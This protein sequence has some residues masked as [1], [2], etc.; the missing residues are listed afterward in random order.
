MGKLNLR[1]INNIIRNNLKKLEDDGWLQIY[2]GEGKGG[3]NR[4]RL[5][6]NKIFEASQS[7]N[8][9]IKF[10]KE[11]YND[12][13]VAPVVRE[14]ARDVDYAVFDDSDTIQGPSAHSDR[15][16]AS[17]RTVINRQRIKKESSVNRQA[18]Q[19]LFKILALSPI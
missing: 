4:Y 6:I 3:V 2:V 5:N 8:A 9:R 12:T 15:T 13:A 7:V 11:N 1:K 10:E 17:Y 18:A 16:Q 19:N 14:P